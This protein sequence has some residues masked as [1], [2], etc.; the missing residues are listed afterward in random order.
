MNRLSRFHVRVTAAALGTLGLTLLTGTP[1]AADDSRIGSNFVYTMSNR[2]AGNSVLGFRVEGEGLFTPIGTFSTGGNGTGAGLGSQGAIALAEGGSRLLAVNA[3]SDTVSAFAVDE[4]GQLDLLGTAPSGGTDPISVTA[5]GR[6]V[7]VLNAGTKTVSGML[8]GDHGLTPLAGSTRSLSTAALAPVQASFTPDGE[9]LIVT[10]KASNT[11]DTFM[12]GKHGL[13]GQLITNVSDGTTPFGFDFDRAGRVV[14][15][16]ASGGAAGASAA[17]S[18]RT[19][20]DGTLHAINQVP[21]GQSA[22]CW[23]VVD[24]RGNHA[25]VTN[26][27][28][29]TVSAYSISHDG[30]LILLAGIAATTGG[31]PIDEAIGGQRLFVLDAAGRIVSARILTSGLL[32]AVSIGATALPGSATGLATTSED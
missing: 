23:V 10:E 30:S 8:L 31:H 19:G 29:G 15:S 7:Y 5:R 2:S 14:V 24:R 21:D 26:T 6:L 13:L 16:D 18:Y 22:A 28:S 11:I 3:G 9:L 27:G 32:G 1:A 12:V 25:Y 17:T 20:E 4:G